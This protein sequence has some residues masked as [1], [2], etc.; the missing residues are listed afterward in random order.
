MPVIHEISG[1]ALQFHNSGW[2][3][4]LYWQKVDKK[5]LKRLNSLINEIRR[6]PQTGIGKPEKLKH[7]MNGL[8]SRRITQEH[9]IIYTFSAKTL[10]ILACRYNY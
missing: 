9:R 10:T 4:Y 7:S 3:D 1:L 6:T 5:I 8:W 2:E